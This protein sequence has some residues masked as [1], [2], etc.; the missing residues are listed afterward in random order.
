M[1]AISLYLSQCKMEDK[2]GTHVDGLKD[3]L[4]SIRYTYCWADGLQSSK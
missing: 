4:Q 1:S 2:R 3:F